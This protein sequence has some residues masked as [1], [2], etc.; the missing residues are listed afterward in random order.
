M[1]VYI[2]FTEKQKIRI[3]DWKSSLPSPKPKQK[4]AYGIIFIPTEER[5]KE[6]HQLFKAVMRSSDG[7]KFVVT[8]KA[9]FH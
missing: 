5:D 6:E 4:R 7:H 8:R 1:D 3:Q 9:S 2:A